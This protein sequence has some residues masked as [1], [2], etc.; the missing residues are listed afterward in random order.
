[1]AKQILKDYLSDIDRLKDGITEESEKILQA[2]DLKDLLSMD[3]VQKKEYLTSVLMDFWEAQENVINDA[4]LLGEK[5]AEML[6][7]A[8]K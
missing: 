8:S 5:K 7:N 6:I 1:M 3:T 2:V 4:I